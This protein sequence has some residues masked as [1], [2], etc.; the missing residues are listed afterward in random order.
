MT[1]LYIGTTRDAVTKPNHHKKVNQQQTLIIFSRNLR[2]PHTDSSLQA[3][4][5]YWWGIPDQ[6]RL[7]NSSEKSQH[8]RFQQMTARMILYYRCLKNTDSY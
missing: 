3:S 7:L 4:G 2:Y 1:A 6:L 8:K 5:R